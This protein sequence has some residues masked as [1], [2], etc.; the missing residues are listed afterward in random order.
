MS[1]FITYIQY[2]AGS[3]KGKTTRGKVLNSPF[4]LGDVDVDYTSAK[5]VSETKVKGTAATEYKANLN[6]FPVV[7]GTVDIVVGAAEYKD[8]GDGKLYLVTSGAI[9]ATEVGTIDYATG[10]ITLAA[11][12]APATD[13]PVVNYAYDNVVIPQNDIPLLNAEIKDIP[14][15]AKPRRIAIYYS[16]MAAFQSKTDYGFDLGEQLAEKAVGELMYKILYPNL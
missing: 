16:Q 5:I 2:T 9:T 6:W 3:N 10:A 11:A 12:Q 13:A 15:V 4:Q 1:G 8:G 7:A 14:L